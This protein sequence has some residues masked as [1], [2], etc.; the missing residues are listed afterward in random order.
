M[1][2]SFDDEGRQ[3]DEKGR[4]HQWWTPED[5]KRFNALASRFGAQYEKFEVFPGSTSTAN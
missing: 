2:H 1:T 4:V 5:I 3:F